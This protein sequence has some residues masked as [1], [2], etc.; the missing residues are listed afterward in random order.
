[1]RSE[2]HPITGIMYRELEGG[3]IEV[4]DVEHARRGVFQWNG[5]WVEGDMTNA[6]N[7]F[8]R[9]IGG[10]NLPEGADIYW[11]M[12]P[13]AGQGIAGAQ[14]IGGSAS[15][16]MEAGYEMPKLIGKY[17]QDPGLMT[18]HGMR[19]AGHIDLD[20]FTKN[21]RKP[22]LVPEVYHLESPM[23]GGPMKIATDR[24]VDPRY[25]D[26][27]V[28]R[29]WK[30]VW[31]MACR[32]DDIPNI[33]DYQVYEIAHLSYIVVRTG[34]NE[35]KAHLNACL[36]RGRMLRDRSGQ[37][38]AEFRCPYHGWS[39]TIDGSLK[40]ITCEWDFPGV[41]EDAKQLV[42]AKVGTWGGF[43][44]IN[45]DM[46]AG[47]LEDFLGPIMIAH[48]Q[49]FNFAGRYKH[50]HVSRVMFGNWKVVMEAFME[51]YHTI[52]THP[53]IMLMSGDGAN[54]RYDVFGNWGRAS[55]LSP[56]YVS[57]QRGM[58]ASKE[59][60]LANYRAAADLNKD[61]LRNIIGEEVEKFSD[62]ELNDG[63]FCDV[64]PNFHPWSGWARIVFRFRPHGDNPNEC[65]MDVMLLGPWAEGKPKPPAVQERRLAPDQPWCEAP[66]IGNL[67][68][69]IDQDCD[70]VAQ[71]Y[72]GLKAKHP[73]HIW[74]SAYQ[75][76][77]IRNFHERYGAWVGQP[78]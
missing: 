53:Q 59:D 65:L 26:L 42:P 74:Y 47:P 10:P 32:E 15:A 16:A 75:E 62:A 58:M 60:V 27:E 13:V 68:R 12:L 8:L 24:F 34:E 29:L 51:A 43:V 77:K 19:S 23:P 4:E 6:D 18:E 17:I 67:A 55:H 14:Q 44:F 7:H 33:G 66:E 61:F 41:R 11:P 28:E 48:Y 9:Y 72:A 38:A 20:F 25:H 39:W 35:F 73:G 1:M 2:P 76:S 37:K 71:V 3:L 21:D 22:E 69:I 57:P 70:N 52:A 50:A 64:F 63:N 40:E 36:H 49:K 30:K 78:V 46:G 31:Q 45:P 5:T 54:L 56:L